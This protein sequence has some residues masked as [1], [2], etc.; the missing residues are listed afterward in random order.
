MVEQH[1]SVLRVHRGVEDVESRHGWM[2][3]VQLPVLGNNMPDY[4]KFGAWAD[5]IYMTANLFYLGNT[6]VGAEAVA[7]NRDDLIGNA[8]SIRV[9][10][11]VLPDEY[12]MLPAND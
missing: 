2:V 4:P 7:F 11:K 1:G 8:G 3:D 5:G 6:Y 10:T 12:S 9:Q